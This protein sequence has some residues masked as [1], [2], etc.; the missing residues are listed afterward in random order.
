MT[1]I[2]THAHVFARG[3]PAIATARYVP[4]YDAPLA[5]Y[6]AFLDGIGAREGVLVQP[7]FL[8]SDNSFLLAALKAAEGRLAG[9]AVVEERRAPE[10]AEAMAAAGIRGLR[11]NLVGRSPEVLALADA[12]A[13][14][15]IA[16]PLGWHVELHADAPDLAA[17]L[18]YLRGFDGRIVIDHFGRPGPD[19]AALVT[20]WAADPR[21]HMKLSAP[22]RVRHPDIRGLAG[23]IVDAYGPERLMWGSD[24]PWT[25]HEE[26][27]KAVSL[28]PG[29]VGLDG[30]TIA[31]MEATARRLFFELGV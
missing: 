27:A 12:T 4:D 14:L 16:A 28:L 7:S 15:A 25:Q 21:V 2:D 23:R 3:L 30:A 9:V 8:G 6:L 17:A 26:A 13:M 29:A 18:P 5:A 19:D 22:Y 11:Y 10:A 20:S 24:W 31:T 1:T